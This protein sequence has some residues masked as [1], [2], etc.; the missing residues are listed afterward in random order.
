MSIIKVECVADRPPSWKCFDPFFCK[1]CRLY[2]ECKREY[3]SWNDPEDIK[4]SEI[5]ERSKDIIKKQEG[6]QDHD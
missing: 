3:E 4:L 2:K 5:I 1:E 6:S